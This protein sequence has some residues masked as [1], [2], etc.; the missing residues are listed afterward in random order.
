MALIPIYVKGV[1]EEDVLEGPIGQQ[2]R[3][4]GVKRRKPRR[5]V[6]QEPPIHTLFVN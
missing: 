3:T 6:V 1:L 2:R 5:L 4:C